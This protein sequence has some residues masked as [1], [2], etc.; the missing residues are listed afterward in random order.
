M[1]GDFMTHRVTFGDF[2]A[3]D[4]LGWIHRYLLCG[5]R[6]FPNR[7]SKDYQIWKCEND[8]VVVFN[9]VEFL[10]VAPILLVD[11]HTKFKNDV[12]RS[13]TIML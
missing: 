12:A 11:H 13:P 6:V 8:N 2:M 9:V 10:A 3:G 5:K 4:F 7:I 1:A